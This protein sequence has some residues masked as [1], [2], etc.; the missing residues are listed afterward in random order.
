[1]FNRV[2][3][4]VAVSLIEKVYLAYRDRQMFTLLKHAICAAVS[5]VL[6]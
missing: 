1:M 5:Y 6:I 3:K 4:I 2:K